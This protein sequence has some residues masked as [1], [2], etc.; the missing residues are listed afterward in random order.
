MNKQETNNAV[1]EQL[2]KQMEELSQR[3]SNLELAL[4]ASNIVAWNYYFKTDRLLIDNADQI[5]GFKPGTEFS[6]KQLID[7]VHP[8]D[9]DLLHTN[10]P[11]HSEKYPDNHEYSFRVKNKNNVYRWLVSIG[12]LV[13]DGD[14]NNRIVGTLHDITYRK[15]TEAA[16]S[17]SE[18]KFQ[19]IS[20]H[21]HEGIILHENEIITDI[22]DRVKRIFGYEVESFVG[23]PLKKLFANCSFKSLASTKKQNHYECQATDRNG[24]I[25]YLEVYNYTSNDNNNGL[26]LLHSITKRKKAELNLIKERSALEENIALKKEEVKAKDHLIS[27]NQKYYKNLLQNLQGVA[28]RYKPLNQKYSAWE[29]DFISDGSLKLLGFTPEEIESNHVKIEDLIKSKALAD[30]IWKE[31][32]I[33]LKKQKPFNVQYPVST[34]SGETRWVSDS[35]LGI[36]NEEGKLEALEG[37]IVDITEEKLRELSYSTLL[38]NMQGMAYRSEMSKNKLK[39]TFISDGCLPLTGYAAEEIIS[40]P[41][42]FETKIVVKEH[43][44][45]VWGEILDCLKE[46]QPFEVT[47]P[48]ITKEGEKRWAFER[49]VGLYN[50]DNELIAVE[51]VIVDVTTAKEQE[52]KYRLAQETI[53]KAP[54][55]IEWLREDG[56]YY[57]VNDHAV[58]ISGFSKKEFYNTKIYEIDPIVSKKGWKRIFEERQSKSVKDLE[59]P[60]PKKDGTSIPSLVSASNIEFEGNVFNCSYISDISELKKA[61]LELKKANDELSAS[62]E[63][64][65]LQSEELA[66][67]NENLEL[68]KD[69]LESTIYK[70]KNTKDQLVQAEKMASLGVLVAGIAHEL[71]NPI[72]YI[73]SSIEALHEVLNDLRIFLDTYEKINKDNVAEILEEIEDLNADI[74]FDELR[75]DFR[76]MLT[77]IN[78]GADQAYQIIKGLRSFSRLDKEKTELQNIHHNIENVLLML[79]NSYKYNIQ[80]KKDFGDIPPIECAPGQINQVFMNLIGNAIQAIEGKGAITIKTRKDN[81]RVI[82][83]VSDTGSGIKEEN[84]KRI[85]EPFFTTKDPG[86]GTGL[87]LSISLGIVQDHNG[88]INLESG[89]NGT[90][91]I[92]TLPIKQSESVE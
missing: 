1:V 19:L 31:I 86:E 36:F 71:N 55:I 35:G 37:V 44:K 41:R 24:E 62:E 38:K 6:L 8:E 30:K 60:Y 25:I 2:K 70:L 69:E 46:Q 7:R 33:A 34:K 18:N 39:T 26:V 48:I 14:E 88:S 20:N 49:G 50:E 4:Q 3:N 87:G 42:F 21:S 66:S 85:F 64:L 74:T 59:M 61:Q 16:F 43:Q 72:N 76:K 51:G 54:I 77:N 27:V 28:Y 56:S 90:T 22:N 52:K 84:Q 80:I 83:S 9:K 75:S 5:L 91:F 82:I 65:R 29:T 53:D 15:E 40:H 32:K 11:K 79:K 47:Y 68:Q 17:S 78:D 81:D 67:L 63:E 57:Y 58:K 12:R 10:F 73:R 23:K 89:K 13:K 45:E 92:V